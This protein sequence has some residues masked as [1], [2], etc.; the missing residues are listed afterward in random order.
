MPI[1]PLDHPE[2]LAA[3]LGVMLYPGNDEADPQKARAFAAHYLAEPLRRLKEA[4]GTLSYE[5]LQRIASDAGARLDDLEIRWWDATA[6]GELFKTLFALANTDPG[7]A[8]WE[9]AIKLAE[10]T[11]A[12]HHVAGSRSALWS[13]RT[14][15]LSVAHLWGAWCIREGR[16]VSRPE[17]GYDGWHDFQFFL[18]EAEVLREWGQSWRPPRD[19]AN[20]PLPAEVW[21]V[22]E[23]WAPPERNPSWPLTGGIP[24]LS[25]P[26]NLLAH[27]K[28]SGRPRKAG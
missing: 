21:R 12:K 3:T 7:L 5:D 8:S 1:L 13:A 27:L 4:G 10:L 14:R 22:P 2:P 6:T 18:A 9:S 28:R 23:G 19:K 15:F 17:V 20:P 16:F 11:A 25:V 26:A 24:G